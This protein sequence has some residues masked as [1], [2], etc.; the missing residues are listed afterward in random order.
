MKSFIYLSVFAV[1]FFTLSVTI[2]PFAH[3]GVSLDVDGD[4]YTI[5]GSGLGLDCNDGNALIN[6][7]ATEIPY[8][9]IDQDCNSSDL[10][11]VD[12]DTYAS[13]QAV[14]GTPDCDDTNSA[15][16]P[17]ATEIV[18]DGID[19]DCSGADKTP[20]QA[21]NELISIANGNNVKT[22]PLDNAPKIL[23]DNN[24]TNDKSVCGKLDAFINQ[25]NADKKTPSILKD[26]LIQKTN[27]IKTA[28]GC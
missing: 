3:A 27:E 25:L 13:T 23:N 14:G 8:D 19:Q 6:P 4:G 5:D 17:G 12:A 7:G 16:H 18:G 15:I 10:T 9:G 26:P 28:L 22:S 2:I 21:I 24:P 1:L 20:V 11:D